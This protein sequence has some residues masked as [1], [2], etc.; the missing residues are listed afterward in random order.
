[1]AELVGGAL[2]GGLREDE[3]QGEEGGERKTAH[4][5]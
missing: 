2:L 5:P 4:T 1:L 3:G